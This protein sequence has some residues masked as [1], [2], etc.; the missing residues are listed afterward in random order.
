MT[1]Q[2]SLNCTQKLELTEYHGI[3]FCHTRQEYAFSL[4]NHTLKEYMEVTPLSFF[5]RTMLAIMTKKQTV[6]STLTAYQIETV[7][8]IEL[9]IFNQLESEEPN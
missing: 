9:L 8:F 1:Q 2:G 3:L 4:Q 7:M 5:L 6:K